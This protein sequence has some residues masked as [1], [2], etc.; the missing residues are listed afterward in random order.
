LRTQAGLLIG[1]RRAKLFNSNVSGWKE[2]SGGPI[3]FAPIIAGREA[4][5]PEEAI[6]NGFHTHPLSSTMLEATM[7]VVQTIVLISGS[8]LSAFAFLG[9][10]ATGGPPFSP[11]ITAC[12]M[13]K[14]VQIAALSAIRSAW[15]P[16][17]EFLWSVTTRPFG[18]TKLI[19]PISRIGNPRERSE[20]QIDL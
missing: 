10:A 12:H 3:S 6:F 16:L 11:S 2:Y 20:V 17:Q 4:L 13:T 15:K 14:V 1:P 8:A 9:S 5:G 19:E 18:T 7:K